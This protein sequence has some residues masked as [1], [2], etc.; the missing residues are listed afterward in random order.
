MTETIEKLE[1]KY[2]RLLRVY[3]VMVVFLTLM[4]ILAFAVRWEQWFAPHTYRALHDCIQQ[5]V[6]K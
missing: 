1:A 5:C 6:Q 3:Q 4:L 2:D